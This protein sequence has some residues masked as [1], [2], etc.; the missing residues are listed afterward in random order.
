MD[1][2]LD[3]LVSEAAGVSREFAKELIVSGKCSVLGRV[4]RKPGA[5]FPENTA[6]FVD[7]VPPQFVSRGGLK[8]AKALR[9]F[10]L[11]LQNKYCLDVGAATGGF[12]DCM[13][14][15][16]AKSVFAVE[17]GIGQLHPKLAADPRVISR[18][19]LD[20]RDLSPEE[21]PFEPEFI[22][23]DLS[24]ISL[25]LVLPKISEF[26]AK[27]GQIVLLAK[28]QFEVGPG[29]V[30]KRGVARRPNDH[31]AAIERVCE[32]VKT[33][34]LRPAGLDFSPIKGQNGNREYLFFADRIGG[35][36]LSKSTI[37][38]VVNR[39]FMEL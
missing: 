4:R 21:L 2:R 29:R 14:Q 17:N 16:G 19:G 31:I 27:S 24:F 26:L 38:K 32:A 12:T 25:T 28:P 22:A 7:A 9:V 37:Q 6:V 34:G 30:D 35:V 10:N 33:C 5:K 13:L 20:I 11:E 23:V 1:R 39:A 18:E 8:L 3:L 36:E 15:N